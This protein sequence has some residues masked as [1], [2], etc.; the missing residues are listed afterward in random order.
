M[1]LKGEA[2]ASRL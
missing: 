1:D 2:K